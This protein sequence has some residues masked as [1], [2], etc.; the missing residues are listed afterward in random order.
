M[1]LL[2]VIPEGMSGSETEFSLNKRLHLIIH[3]ATQSRFQFHS[4]YLV[5]LLCFMI[6]DTFSGPESFFAEVARDDNSLKVV[7][8]NVILDIYA[9]AFF[10][11]HC[12]AI[13]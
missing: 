3:H 7:G 12:T 8:F 1:I 4:E 5:V 13:G 6:P 10:S 9:V 2:S 11:A